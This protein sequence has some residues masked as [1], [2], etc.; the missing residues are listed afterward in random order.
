MRKPAEPSAPKTS[1]PKPEDEPTRLITGTVV[2]VT[3]GPEGFRPLQ[4]TSLAVGPF[5]IQ[6]ESREGETLEDLIADA[7]ARLERVAEI[8]LAKKVETFKA[9]ARGVDKAIRRR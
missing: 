7:H 9:R 2:T 8:E 3:W 6:V 1:L 5:S 4:Y